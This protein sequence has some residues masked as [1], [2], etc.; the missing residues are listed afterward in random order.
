MN[1][2]L[3]ILTCALIYC[4]LMPLPA[5]AARDNKVTFSDHSSAVI[6]QLSVLNEMKHWSTPDSTRISLEL[7]RDVAWEAHE[8]GKAAPDKPGRVYVDL[9]RTRLGKNVRDITI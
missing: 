9:K 8:L 6:P 4:L 3:Y 1:R 5:I 2:F 7:D